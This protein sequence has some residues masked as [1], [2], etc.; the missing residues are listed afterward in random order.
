MVQ[1]VMELSTLKT[2]YQ[3]EKEGADRIENLDQLVNAAVCL[4]RKKALA[5]MR[6]HCRPRAEKHGFQQRRCADH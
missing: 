2:H 5:K 3:T 6:R 4:C 1:M